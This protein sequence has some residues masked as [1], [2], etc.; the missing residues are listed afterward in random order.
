ML[1]SH[2]KAIQAAFT[3]IAEACGAKTV[4]PMEK[5]LYAATACPGNTG[6]GCAI[7]AW[8]SACGAG[9]TDPIFPDKAFVETGAVLVEW[10]ETRIVGQHYFTIAAYHGE[11]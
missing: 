8:C 4:N 5:G 2:S 11:L 10:L 3:E 7:R 6:A 9:S 1:N